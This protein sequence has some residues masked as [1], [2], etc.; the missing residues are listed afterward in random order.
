MTSAK[1]YRS[2]EAQASAF[3]REYP[4]EQG[5]MPAAHGSENPVSAG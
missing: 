3:T 2:G 5:Q 4:P 1:D